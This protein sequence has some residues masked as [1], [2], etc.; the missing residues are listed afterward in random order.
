MRHVRFIKKFGCAHLK[1]NTN[2]RRPAGTTPEDLKQM[3]ITLNELGKRIHAEGLKFGVHAHMWTQLENRRELD[4]IAETTDPRYVQFVLDT[5]HITMAGMDPV[6]LTKA[7]G[8]RIVEFHL[9]DTMPEHR[10][11]AKQRREGWPGRNRSGH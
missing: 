1:I 4:T 11:G 2:V 9:K 8:H 6:E 10:G 3:A 7:L 5:G